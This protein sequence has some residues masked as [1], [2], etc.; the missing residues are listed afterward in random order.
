MK[1]SYTPYIEDILIAVE[2]FERF[3]PDITVE[4][5]AQDNKTSSAVL[6]KLEVIGNTAK[7]IPHTLRRKYPDTP[8]RG[9]PETKD[10]LFHAYLNP[11]LDS[12]SRSSDSKNLT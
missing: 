9:M 11:K 6:R 3:V 5:F 8:Q 12:R 2:A 1:H 7:H 4:G 10:K